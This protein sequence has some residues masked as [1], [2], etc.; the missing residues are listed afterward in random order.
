MYRKIIGILICILFVVTGI[1]PLCVTSDNITINE[2]NIGTTN[3]IMLYPSD[4][5]HI[6]H[7]NIIQI[8]MQVI[9]HIYLL[10]TRLVFGIGNK[11]V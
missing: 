8:L 11:M 2:N 10:L 7:I 3:T 6:H 5:A 1:V 4:D 9:Y